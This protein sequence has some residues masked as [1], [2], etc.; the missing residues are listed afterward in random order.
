MAIGQGHCP[1]PWLF[2]KSVS[3]TLH[4]TA[5]YDILCQSVGVV[6]GINVGKY[7]IHGVYDYYLSDFVSLW[8]YDVIH[9]LRE[10]PRLHLMLL[11]VA[12]GMFGQPPSAWLR[13]IHLLGE[14]R[15]P[16]SSSGF[17]RGFFILFKWCIQQW[18]N[19][20][21]VASSVGT[22]TVVTRDHQGPPKEPP[23][24]AAPG[25]S[26]TQRTLR[27]V[28]FRHSETQGISRIWN[29]SGPDTC[30][31]LFEVVCC[32]LLRRPC[33]STNRWLST[34]MLIHRLRVPASPPHNAIDWGVVFLDLHQPNLGDACS[35]VAACHEPGFSHS[36][37]V[38]VLPSAVWPWHDAFSKEGT[39]YPRGR[40]IGKGT[41]PTSKGHRQ[42]N[43]PSATCDP[44]LSPQLADIGRSRAKRLQDKPWTPETPIAGRP[45]L[46]VVNAPRKL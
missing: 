33:S 30:W 8:V 5:M 24:W 4:G 41:L 26:S 27:H 40:G 45:T 29:V 18:C 39:I 9:P 37:C 12:Q 25:V 1:L 19:I 22:W 14:V 7:S 2:Q 21:H 3:H 42:R 32:W 31:L 10:R 44:S 17:F 16:A 35:S 34:S 11:R 38:L 13:A 23:G 15:P 28:F 36:F 6:W 20:T 46:G 43:K